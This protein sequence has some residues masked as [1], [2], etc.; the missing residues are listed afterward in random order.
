MAEK[1]IKIKNFIDL[2][3]EF[4]DIKNVQIEKICEKILILKLEDL[5]IN[6][7][8][9]V[10]EK[11]KENQ[12]LDDLLINKIN[13]LLENK[14]I[15]EI[16]NKIRNYCDNLSCDVDENDVF[17][18]LKILIEK[19]KTRNQYSLKISKMIT[20]ILTLIPKIIASIEKY[21]EYEDVETR[22]KL[23]DL[24]FE[25]EIK[26]VKGHIIESALLAL[27]PKL[28]EQKIENI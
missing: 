25:S 26:F 15:P 16:E 4:S 11:I 5:P 6:S 8:I 7:L 9:L 17:E 24:I 27:K 2:I 12:E 14:V 21:E 22:K 13:L 18:D 20:R 1:S 3:N 28:L 19:N 23:Y 10:R